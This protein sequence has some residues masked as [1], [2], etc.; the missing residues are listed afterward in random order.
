MV[1]YRGRVAPCARGEYTPKMRTVNHAILGAGGVGGFL[2]A[3]L[4]EAGDRVTLL[5]RPETAAGYPERVLLESPFGRF[6]P[7]VDH[8]TELAIDVDV[9]WIAVKATQLAAGLRAVP[10]VG[11][12]GAVVPLLNGIDH[13]PLLRARCG[14]DRLVAA[15][16]GIESERVAP[17]HFV[18]RSPFAIL[19]WS[20]SGEARLA[21]AARALGG[22]GCRC[23]LSADEATM[24]WRKLVILA[25]LALCTTAAGGALGE[26]MGDPVWR[27]R[28]ERS[29]DEACA[30][31]AA[32]GADVDAAQSLRRVQGL[33][34]SLRT[35]MQKDVASGAPPELDAIGGP[36]VRGGE[37]HGIDVSTTAALVAAIAAIVDRDAA[38]AGARRQ[39]AGS[40]ADQTLPPARPT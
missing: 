40:S 11:R 19:T 35:S 1:P 36:I 16:I 13:V 5:L 29:I 34:A 27:G 22:F 15:T 3:L 39:S 14:A 28:L 7:R 24:L 33:P 21:A 4:A 18:H 20:T 10:E 12:A 23:E 25:P 32:S 9:L 38:G 17:G 30:V 2:A 31:A 37:R 26:V 8:A 6:T